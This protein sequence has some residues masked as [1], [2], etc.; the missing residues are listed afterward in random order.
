ME[1]VKIKVSHQTKRSV[2]KTDY[3]TNALQQVLQ[4]ILMDYEYY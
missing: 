1:L 4:I 3:L 2:I